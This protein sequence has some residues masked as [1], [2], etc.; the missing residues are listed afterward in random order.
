MAETKRKGCLG[1]SFPI[2]IGIVIVFLALVVTG[3]LADHIGLHNALLLNT[4]LPVVGMMAVVSMR[5]LARRVA[6]SDAVSG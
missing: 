4:G 6:A 3:F 5:Q 2:F 1:C